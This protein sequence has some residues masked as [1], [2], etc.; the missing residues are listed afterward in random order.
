MAPSAGSWSAGAAELAGPAASAEDRPARIDALSIS[1]L[2]ASLIVPSPLSTSSASQP[3]AAA[4]EA[5]S[6]ASPRR[7]V[8]T[9][10][11]SALA[12]SVRT[13]TSRTGLVVVVARGLTISSAR[14]RIG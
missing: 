2:T 10:S 12:A 4:S 8:S 6:R 1:P 13:I 11:I 7:R 3:A 9:T 5:I 14:T